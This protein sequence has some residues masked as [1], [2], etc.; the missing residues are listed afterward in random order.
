[1]MPDINIFLEA[2]GELCTSGSLRGFVILDI[3]SDKFKFGERDMQRTLYTI[4]AN[5]AEFGSL[6]EKAVL[7]VSNI[8]Y[9]IVRPPIVKNDEITF[10]CEKA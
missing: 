6:K 4:K 9:Q 2:T 3:A 1:M 5:R 10:V 7:R 8:N